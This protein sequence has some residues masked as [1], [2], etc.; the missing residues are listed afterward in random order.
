MPKMGLLQSRGRRNHMQRGACAVLSS[1][2]ARLHG[3][4]WDVSVAQ[5]AVYDL[6][7]I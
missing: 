7:S 2:R 6:L 1:L 3:L 4:Q 5:I